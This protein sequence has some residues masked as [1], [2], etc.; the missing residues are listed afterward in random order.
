MTQMTTCDLHNETIIRL[1]KRIA[2]LERDAK[3][4]YDSMTETVL[5]EMNRAE[6]AEARVAELEEE[7]AGWQRTMDE[8]LNTG[9]GSYRP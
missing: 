5:K 3:T 8:A 2:E 9:D 7:L 6:K 4:T 1:E